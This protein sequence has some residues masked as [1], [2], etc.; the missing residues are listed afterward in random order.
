MLKIRMYIFSQGRKRRN[1]SRGS[2]IADSDMSKFVRKAKQS[3]GKSLRK[4]YAPNTRQS[5][6]FACSDEFLNRLHE[7][8]VRT[9]SCNHHGI[10][11]DC[12]QRDERMGWLNDLSSRLFQTCNNFGMEIFFEKITDD[13]TDTMVKTVQ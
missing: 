9:E 8:S 11:T 1:L 4:N 2:P 10:L 13:I 5:G 7:I 3:F 6:K 12:P